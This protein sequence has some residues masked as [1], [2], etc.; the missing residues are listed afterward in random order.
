MPRQQTIRVNQGYKID[1]KWEALALAYKGLRRLTRLAW[2][3][4][5]E[6]GLLLVVL[7]VRNLTGR[8]MPSGAAWAVTA[9]VIAA[10][11]I[12]PTSRALVLGRLGCARTRR[13]LLACMRETRVAT[14]TGRLPLVL[15]CRTTRAGERLTLGLFPGQSAEL[16]DARTEELRAAARAAD[17]TV[18]RDPARADRVVL[19]VIRR[20][21]LAGPALPSPLLAY[22]AALHDTDTAAPA[23]APAAAGTLPDSTEEMA[24]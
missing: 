15:R 12:A 2:R 16:L 7:A 19:D 5:T 14:S 11:L 9:S 13:R 18:T 3:Y 4:R 1:S 20:D 22:A 21:P 17:L 24:R 23:A 10:V 6:L 8:H